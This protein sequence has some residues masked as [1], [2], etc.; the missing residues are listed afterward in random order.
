MSKDNALRFA[1]GILEQNCKS[2]I[3]V[4]NVD[5]VESVRA[6]KGN[7]LDILKCMSMIA[8]ELADKLE[9]PI[10]KVLDDFN[11]GTIEAYKIYQKAK[12]EKSDLN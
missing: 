3:M 12:S 9:L 1:A 7:G 8:I 5:D 11:E 10:D 6:A 2:Y 4:A